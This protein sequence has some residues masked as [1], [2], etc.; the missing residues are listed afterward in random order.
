[1][2]FSRNLKSQKTGMPPVL[3]PFC[4]VLYLNSEYDKDTILVYIL[5]LALHGF[6]FLGNLFYFKSLFVLLKLFW[7]CKH[8][9]AF[10]EL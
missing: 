5:Y 9:K 4:F 10:L 8:F 7:Y 2:L 1:M 3:W 6:S